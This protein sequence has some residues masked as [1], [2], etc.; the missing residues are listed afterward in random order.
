MKI[1][2]T[3]IIFIFVLATLGFSQQDSILIDKKEVFTLPEK[4]SF[5][6]GISANPFL[7]YFGNL[8]RLEGYNSLYPSLLNGQIYTKY[9]TSSNNAI[10]LRAG[11]NRNNTVDEFR[12]RYDMNN[13]LFVTDIRESQY[14]NFNLMLGY[15][16]RKG[17]GRLQFYYGA[18][19]GFRHVTET[20][21]YT[22]G[23]A[24]ASNNPFPSTAFYSPPLPNRPLEISNEGGT[25]LIIRGLVG[26][27]YFIFSGVSLGT[28][29]GLDLNH[30]FLSV[31]K[32]KYEHWD[33]SAGTARVNEYKFEST[34]TRL[35]TYIGSLFVLFHF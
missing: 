27:E 29:L 28:E 10:R 34:S 21:N 9:F 8:F 6:I 7:N 24:Y 35:N 16:W 23:N 19:A 11:I 32:E 18:D 25:E 30:N 31:K 26:L 14:R 3:T 5:A 13:S 33:S 1:F 15:E 20:I 4:G 12:V 22:Y 2:S 17:I